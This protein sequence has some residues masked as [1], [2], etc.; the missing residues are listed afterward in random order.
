[1]YV[2]SELF[3]YHHSLRTQFSII[4]NHLI[5]IIP[6]SSFEA[7]R[8]MVSKDKGIETSNTCSCLP[9]P[10]KQALLHVIKNV[11]CTAEGFWKGATCTFLCRW[12]NTYQCLC[13][14]R[15]RD[16]SYCCSKGTSKPVGKGYR[17]LHCST[18]KSLF[19]YL[20]IQGKYRFKL[21]LET[22]TCVPVSS[23]FQSVSLSCS[24]HLYTGK[25]HI[26]IIMIII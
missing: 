12:K 17:N 7:L 15:A 21:R 9:V 1:M 23:L 20:G 19:Y 22:C 18:F 10:P 11:F 25:S 26:T 16:K 5:I 13:K 3:L 2:C 8:N 24:R 14:Q 6:I 4:L